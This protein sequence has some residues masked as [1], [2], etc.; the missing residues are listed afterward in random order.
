[1]SAAAIA[2]AWSAVMNPYMSRTH[3]FMSRRTTGAPVSSSVVVFTSNLLIMSFT[4]RGSHFPH[5]L[6]GNISIYNFAY[7]V[8]FGS[9]DIYHSIGSEPGL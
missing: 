8:Y 3:S 6:H 7:T 5:M 2:S 9:P 1:M 4:S